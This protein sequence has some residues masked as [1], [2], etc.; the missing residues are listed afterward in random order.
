[1]QSFNRYI[2]EREIETLNEGLLGKVSEW[3]KN[4]F[5]SQKELSP[6]EVTFTIDN[7]NIKNIKSP[8]S[9]SKL[10]DT[11]ADKNEM[12][13]I[14]DKNIGF[15][16]TSKLIS[17]KNEYFVHESP[18][19]KKKIEYPIKIDRYFYI[20]DEKTD[21]KKYIGII[22]FDEDTK[23]DENYVNVF[24][25]EVIDSIDNKE[26]VEKYI[27]SIFETNMKNKNFN[28]AKYI[29]SLPEIKKTMTTLLGYKA[30]NNNKNIFFKNFK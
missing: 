18:D 7:K 10:S 17:K 28:G 30:Q 9:P 29:L 13:I 21:N 6:D 15:P 19:D 5:K 22:L 4:L 14:N 12:N 3:F 16:I 8:N 20:M 1:M 2:T 24:N 11:L 25:V 26:A 23:N 27:Y